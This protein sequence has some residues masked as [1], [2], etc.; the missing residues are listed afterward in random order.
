MPTLARHKA[1]LAMLLL[2]GSCAACLGGSGGFR[3]A[4]PEFG[5]WPLR[6][7][8]NTQIVRGI[9]W[10]AI[11]A[12][13]AIEIIAASPNEFGSCLYGELQD[14]LVVIEA[15]RADSIEPGPLRLG[16]WCS[17]DPEIDDY[18]IIGD[19]HSH[20]SFTF[21]DAPCSLSGQDFAS[22][23]NRPEL[24]LSMV[25]CGNGNAVVVL[26]DGRHWNFAWGPPKQ[27]PNPKPPN[28]PRS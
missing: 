5:K 22:F 2:I 27:N 8:V 12:R 14:T 24:A 4:R 7:V 28:A 20:P 25:F 1:F 15:M 3:E 9:N 11:G 19:V 10:E 21:L 18:P 13:L 6:S 23:L 26:R 17:Y 16:M